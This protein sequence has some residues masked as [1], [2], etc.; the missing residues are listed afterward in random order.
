M[1]VRKRNSK[2]NH[3]VDNQVYRASKEVVINYLL[4][5]LIV[6]RPYLYDLRA[7]V[8]PPAYPGCR[9][10]VKGQD[11]TIHALRGRWNK[12][13]YVPNISCILGQ[14][15]KR[16]NCDIKRKKWGRLKRSNMTCEH[17]CTLQLSCALRQIKRALILIYWICKLFVV[18]KET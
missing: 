8:W 2:Y 17:M 16:R 15:L 3:K 1:F 5:A 9:Y 12:T 18:Y 7:T 4:V 14:I 6:T 13:G 10:P 11:S